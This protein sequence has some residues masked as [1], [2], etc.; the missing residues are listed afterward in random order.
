MFISPKETFRKKMFSGKVVVRS[1]TGRK[2]QFKFDSSDEDEENHHRRKYSTAATIFDSDKGILSSARKQRGVDALLEMLPL[3]STRG[4]HRFVVWLSTASKRIQWNPRSMELTIDGVQKNG[5]NMSEI[6]TFLKKKYNDD[7]VYTSAHSHGTFVGVPLGTTHF[8]RTVGEEM[9]SNNIIRNNPYTWAT[10]E[11]H[12][13]ELIDVLADTYGFNT[14][15][16]KYTLSLSALE[17]MRFLSGVEDIK[18]KEE[19][20]EEED[21][22]DNDDDD[23]DD[24]HGD[25]DDDGDDRSEKEEEK[26]LNETMERITEAEEEE[27]RHRDYGRS[28]PKTPPRKSTPLSSRRRRV[29]KK[30][31]ATTLAKRMKEKLEK[32]MKRGKKYPR[33]LRDNPEFAE[34]VGTDK[35]AMQKLLNLETAARMHMKKELRKGHLKTKEQKDETAKTIRE[36]LHSKLIDSRSTADLLA[37]SAKT[38]EKD[39]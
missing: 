32:E 2:R 7:S 16:M 23:D 17:R 8:L 6:L 29:T 11:E 27:R 39:V 3:Y 30:V 5:T 33:W 20:E 9:Y 10:Q 21:D 31:H 22:E 36:Q 12:I 38:L 19:E 13:D 34:L 14:L 18:R 4:L 24:D 26:D 35:N 28:P 1:R 37:R 15:K 25:D